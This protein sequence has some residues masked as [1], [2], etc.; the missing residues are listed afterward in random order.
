VEYGSA[1]A[2]ALVHVQG[3]PLGDIIACAGKRRVSI[4]PAEEWSARANSA[5]ASVDGTNWI[6]AS[7]PWGGRIELGLALRCRLVDHRK[8]HDAAPCIWPRALDIIVYR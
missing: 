5:R 1:W 6:K 8:L 4:E 2:R 3:P 7:M